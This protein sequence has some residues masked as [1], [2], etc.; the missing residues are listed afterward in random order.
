MKAL[1]RISPLL[2][3]GGLGTRLRSVASGL[4]KA[5]VPVA[6]KPF[7]EWILE[8]LIG[9]GFNESILCTGY[10]SELIEKRFGDRF[11]SLNLIYSTEPRPLGTAGALRLAAP[12]LN[13][14]FALVLN[15]DSFCDVDLSAFC[16]DHL[17]SGEDAS[18]SLVH[19]PN[20]ARFGTVACSSEGK[21]V[22]LNEKTGVSEPGWINAGIYLLPKSWLLEIPS[23]R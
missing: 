15:G 11:G 23:D 16:E 4:P 14:E 21:V 10:Q 13:S 8:K 9:S 22:S 5:L 20:T 3:V 19:V 17:N 6:G 12:L 1:P 7:L 2:L 18:M